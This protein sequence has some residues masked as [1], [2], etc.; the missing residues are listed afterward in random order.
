MKINPKPQK[1]IKL[2]KTAQNET[3]MPEN[4]TNWNQNYSPKLNQIN[5]KKTQIGRKLKENGTK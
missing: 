3:K 5:W 4:S 2:K 1:E